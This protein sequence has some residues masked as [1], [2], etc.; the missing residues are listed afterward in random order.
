ML[1]SNNEEEYGFPYNPDMEKQ[2]IDRNDSSTYGY[3]PEIPRLYLRS[4]IFGGSHIREPRKV[5]V[6]N[7]STKHFELRTITTPKLQ[8]RVYLEIVSNAI[9][10]AFKS[11]RM[12]FECTS[13][14]ITM[15][16]D[17]ISI[18]SKG[19]PVPVDIH[20]FFYNQIDNV[21]NRNFGTC[22]EL[23][24]GVIGAGGNSDDS[25]AK[26]GGG[27]NGYGA[28]LTNVFSRF[29]EVEIG[30][31][32]RGFHQ[33]IIWRKNM[34]EKGE[35]IITP[36][37]NVVSNG[38]VDKN[39]AHIYHIQPI[40]DRYDGE[41]FVKITWKQDFRKFGCSNFNDDDLELYMKYAIEASYVAKFVVNFNG[42]KF[43]C[44]N[45][46]N[47]LSN[48]PKEL[49]KNSLIHY[50]FS[51][52]PNVTGKNLER[53]IA[54]LEILPSVE[55]IVLDTPSDSLHISYCNGIYNIDG[56]EHTDSSYREILNVIKD[57]IQ[58]SKTFDKG[59]DISKLNIGDMKKH[60]TIIINYRCN[61]PTFKGQDKEKL[62]K[63]APKIKFSIEEINKIKKF[64]FVNV[65]YTTLTGKYLK[66]MEGKNSKGR[67]K[68]DFNFRDANWFGTERQNET[69]LILCEGNSAGS[70]ILKWIYGTEEKK[71]KYACFLLRGKFKNVTDVGIVE[72]ESNP[73]IAKLINYMGFKHGVDYSTQ[74]GIE[75]L[76]YGQIFCMVDADS[77]G[78]HIQ[79]L[80]MN[81][82]Y[83]VFPSFFLAR[84]FFYVPTPVIRILN[85]PNGNTQ[86]IF[87]NMFDY[88]KYVELN[89]NRKNHVKFFKGLASGNDKFAKEDAIVSPIVFV[90]FDELA[91]QAFDVA[92]KKGLTNERKKWIKF[93][94]DK[95][96][97]Q[98]LHNLNLETNLRL[99]YINISDYI[100]TKLVEYSVDTLSRALPSYKDGL[101][102]SQR[103]VFWYV[104][105]EWNFGHSK[106]PEVNI[107][108]IALGAKTKSKY[109]HGDLT[110]T[111]A[112]MGSNYPGSN[113]IPLMSQEGQF[114][115]RE[116]LGKDIGASR[117]VE[118]RPE[119]IISKIFDKELMDLIEVNIVENKEVE[120]KWIPSKIPLHIIN[121]VIGVATA[122]STEIPSYHPIDIILWI[123]RYITNKECFPLIPWFKGFTGTV[124]MEVFKNKYKKDK[125]LIMEN[126]EMISYYEGLTL[127]TKG[128]YEIVRERNQVYTEEIDGKKQKI[129]HKVKDILITEI[130]IGVSTAKYTFEMDKNCDKV[131]DKSSNSDTPTMILQGWKKGTTFKDLKLIQRTGL[132]NISLIDDD[133][134][135]V[136]FR[137]IYEVLKVYCDNMKELYVLLK[138]KRLEK[139]ESDIIDETKTIKLI[140]LLNDDAIITK[141]QKQSY[142]E[143]QLKVYDIEMIYYTKLGRSAESEEG[144][145][146]HVNKLL[147]LKEEHSIIFNKHHLED[148]YND[149][150]EI[151]NILN[152]LPE[153]QKLPHHQY[154]YVD[155]NIEDLVSGKVKSPFSLKADKLPESI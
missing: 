84:R 112:R 11:Q 57:I 55:L 64:N 100:N 138:A 120:P 111:L 18:K 116:H 93:W 96:D 47:F 91:A 155:T 151:Y 152:V 17:T 65:I 128:N 22:A 144:Y 106:K 23:I 137:N 132:C 76:R 25:I 89:P 99:K 124:E 33:K 32:I 78:S 135:P 44:R 27:Q 34:M 71:D 10:N 73:E 8:E 20:S 74:K 139:L 110:D 92:F 150:M 26:Q 147:K 134:N 140:D 90:N 42:V 38:E 15:D 68:D 1:S 148:W 24:F 115:T 102:K 6:Y 80:V 82:I 87:Y 141:K 49:N 31:N 114:G 122:Y 131:D 143:E 5:Y 21:G 4:H 109:H 29:F 81:F 136:Q 123:L 103:Q 12:G 13:L 56:G 113:N 39:G 48:F 101:K 66:N 127:T 50:E 133:S 37:F 59:L 14:D 35:S 30:D 126:Q 60:A 98:V 45:A 86:H 121:G 53:A 88:K 43:D 3:I 118:T 145:D 7:R 16:S 62:L 52:P 104:L 28:K 117:Y 149:L 69:V 119:P 146:T 75:S 41:N 94:R 58:S 46:S 2:V 154:P 77:D 108:A 70:Y 51:S 79:S 130:P 129:T 19:V 107:E 54:N 83:R 97:T 36:Q 153:Y 142:I 85:A 63:P 95:V 67:I 125:D 61:D 105:L 40:S 72:V 9:D